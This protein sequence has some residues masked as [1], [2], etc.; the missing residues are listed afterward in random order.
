[1]RGRRLHIF[2]VCLSLVACV[3]APAR[4][5]GSVTLTGYES[6]RFRWKDIAGNAYAAAYQDSYSYTQAEVSVTQSK[7]IDILSPNRSVVTLLNT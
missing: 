2:R 6:G 5:S 4:A 7:R 3:P 1:M